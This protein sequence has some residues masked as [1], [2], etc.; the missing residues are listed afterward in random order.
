MGDTMETTEIRWQRH[1]E[2]GRRYASGGDYAQAEQALF[3]AVKEAMALGPADLRVAASLTML[4]KVKHAQGQR[5]RAEA[6]FRRALAIREQALGAEHYG[7]VQSLNELAAVSYE[8]GQLGEAAELYARALAISDRQLAPDHP[9]LALAL[10]NLARVHFKAGD[11]L[12]AEPLLVRLLGIKERTLGPDHPDVAAILMALARVR[13]MTGHHDD[14]EQMA[15][16]A[17]AIREAVLPPDDPA[18]AISLDLVAYF[19]AGRAK[20]ERLAADAERILRGASAAETGALDAMLTALADEERQLRERARAIRAPH[21]P[22]AGAEPPTLERAPGERP[23]AAPASTA[24]VQPIPVLRSVLSVAPAP[25]RPIAALGE[26]PRAADDAVQVIVPVERAQPPLRRRALIAAVAAAIVAAGAIGLVVGRG[27]RAPATAERA[28]TAGQVSGGAVDISVAPPA[29]A[30]PEPVEIV[31]ADPARDGGPGTAAYAARRAAAL[32]GENA[33][34][35]STHG[36]IPSLHDMRRLTRMMD[37]AGTRAA[38]AIT[39]H[40]DSLG[41]KVDLRPPTFQ[42][43]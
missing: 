40:A 18:I 23:A 33:T 27:L 30:M 13:S 6:L 37:R 10:Y 17:L 32:R 43:P 42:K 22:P 36:A 16:R 11:H 19:C 39:V 5:A 3:A 12:Q 20:R 2:A 34:G 7:L 29:A 35:A 31:P 4:G 15:R 14:G 26:P 28:E 8:G 24:P 21:A 38:R 25:A 1:V 41:R 9:D